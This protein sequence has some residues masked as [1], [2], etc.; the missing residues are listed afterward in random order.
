MIFFR[1]PLAFVESHHTF[2]LLC[3]TLLSV[4]AVSLFFFSYTFIVY[5][6]NY[7]CIINMMNSMGLE[8]GL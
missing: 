4:T 3:D 1:Q 6:N 5:R 2:I 8:L 7:T